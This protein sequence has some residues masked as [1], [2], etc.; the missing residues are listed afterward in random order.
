MAE[1]RDTQL[2]CPMTDCFIHCSNDI[3][4]LVAPTN[5]ESWNTLLR[6]ANISGH[7]PIL[8]LAKDLPEGSIPSLF[9]HRKCRSI[10]IMKKLLDRIVAKE[11]PSENSL[12]EDSRKSTR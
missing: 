9:Y 10:F 6:A 5:V 2:K 11:S 7:S 12:P 8:D 3:L 1:Q 4:K